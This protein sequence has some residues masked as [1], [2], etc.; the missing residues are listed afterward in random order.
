MTF[1][2]WWKGY[3]VEF[4]YIRDSFGGLDMV[5]IAYEAAKAA[6]NE[7]AEHAFDRGVIAE[8]ESHQCTK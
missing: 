8:R 5:E 1:E 2:Q 7:S 3:Q 6:W 4:N